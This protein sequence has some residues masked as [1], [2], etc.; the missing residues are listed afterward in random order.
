MIF[1]MV[2]RSMSSMCGIA[3]VDDGKEGDWNNSIKVTI[4]VHVST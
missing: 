1:K 3:A 2:F 4:E